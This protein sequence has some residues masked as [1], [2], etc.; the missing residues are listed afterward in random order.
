MGGFF[1]QFGL[2]V[3]ALMAASLS[4]LS[5]LAVIIWLPESL[6]AEER[7]QLKTNPHTVFNL[8]NLVDELRRPCVGPLLLIRLFYSFAFTLFQSNFSLY[9]KEVLGLDVRNTGLVL[10]Y[11][12][13]LSVIVQGLA[14]SRLTKAYKERNLI[15]TSIV[16]LA[17]SLLIWGFTRNIWLLLIILAPIALGAGILNT[18]LTSQLTKSVY[19]EDVGGT[20]GLAN[21][22]QTV[23]Q[24]VTPGA[25]GLLLTI[26]GPWSLGVISSFFMVLAYLTSRSKSTINSNLDNESPCYQKV[27]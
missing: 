2:N 9:A 11:V 20:L 21:S 19:K 6:P 7:Q 24:I 27:S 1:S 3:P 14:I 16:M 22:M 12:G 26:S 5:L 15:V 17:V 13:L 18:L 8:A 23:A 25:G 10:T 4:I